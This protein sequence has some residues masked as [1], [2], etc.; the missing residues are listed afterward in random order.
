M[1]QTIK[2]HKQ[3]ANYI[4]R[5]IEINEGKKAPETTIEIKTIAGNWSMRINELL[6][7]YDFYKEVLNTKINE[8]QEEYVSGIIGS[9]YTMG[10]MIGDDKFYEHWA[11][12]YFLCIKRMFPEKH[13]LTKEEDDKIIDGVKT[14]YEE[15][16]QLKTDLET[17]AK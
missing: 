10:T 5:E 2:K 11:A 7:L 3:V 8:N 1:K 13:G 6:P 15:I 12:I 14:L 9:A 17:K 4:I 16:A